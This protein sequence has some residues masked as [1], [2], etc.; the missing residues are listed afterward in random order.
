VSTVVFAGPE[1]SAGGDWGARIAPGPV[2]GLAA[3]DGRAWL[4]TGHAAYETRDVGLRFV[5]LAPPGES[6]SV[7]AAAND[8]PLVAPGSQVLAL[9]GGAWVVRWEMQ[10]ALEGETICGLVPLDGGVLALT[11]RRRVL[12]GTAGD[13][14]LRDDSEGLP[15]P[16]AGGAYQT[17][18]VHVVDEW[19]FAYVGGLYLRRAGE[20]RWAR[21][22]DR[23]PPELAGIV[24]SQSAEWVRSPWARDV[25]IG[26][27]GTQIFASGPGRPL[28]PLWRAP[29][30][31]PHT[32]K[33]LVAGAN[34]VVLSLRRA[35]PALS[36]LAIA[37]GRMDAIRLPVQ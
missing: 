13:R 16:L 8:G 18:N 24:A 2:L 15:S 33:R 34:A 9:E 31:A 35:T 6:M 37:D 10:S 17:P 32:P 4:L 7:L 36:G 26:H 29:A 19:H 25:W 27:D 22:A 30:G 20:A 3:R 12:R 28:A 21:A 11:N 14:S 1:R 23:A 5:A